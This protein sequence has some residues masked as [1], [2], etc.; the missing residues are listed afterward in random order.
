MLHQYD[1]ERGCAEDSISMVIT[2]GF[3]IRVS[4]PE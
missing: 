2:L 3:A 1:I 4:L